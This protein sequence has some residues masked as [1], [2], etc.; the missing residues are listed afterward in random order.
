MADHD[1]RFKLLLE[2]FFP[3]FFLLFF[4]SWAARFDFTKIEWLKQ[5]AFTDPTQ[6]TRLLLDVV[7]KLATKQP[8]PG[9]RPGEPDSWVA[10][11]HVEVEGADSVAALRPRMHDY[12]SELR[13]RNALPVLPLAL[14]LHVGLDGIGIDVYEEYVF[15]LRILHFQYLYVGLPALDGEQYLTGENILGA[16]LAALMRLPEARRTELC[17]QALRRVAG[18]EENDYRRSC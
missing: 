10:V 16:A 18:S 7:A 14:Y 8:V 1:Q 15:D 3:E 17:E 11:I 13:Q 4:P 5:E 2:E 9:Q 6:G 12:H